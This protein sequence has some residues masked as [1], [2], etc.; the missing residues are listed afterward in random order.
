MEFNVMIT[1][2]T[3]VLFHIFDLHTQKLIFPNVLCKMMKL[4]TNIFPLTLVFGKYFLQRI[5]K[6]L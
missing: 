4:H 5:V 2:V 3:I 1:K 6:K